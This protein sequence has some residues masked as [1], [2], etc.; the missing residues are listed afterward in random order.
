M[1]YWVHPT[2]HVSI[3][4]LALQFVSDLSLY[5]RPADVTTTRP[6]RATLLHQATRPFLLCRRAYR[7]LLRH[8]APGGLR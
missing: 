2:L 3:G 7:I 4:F 6:F 5:Q 1:C 8:Q